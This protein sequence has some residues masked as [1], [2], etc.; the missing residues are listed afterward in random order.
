MLAVDDDLEPPAGRPAPGHDCDLGA[1]EPQLGRGVLRRGRE[2]ASRP[3]HRRLV[4]VFQAPLSV[5]RWDVARTS[6]RPTARPASV[7]VRCPTASSARA[8]QRCSRV[9][10]S[11]TVQAGA[12]RCLCTWTRAPCRH[13]LAFRA[14]RSE[15]RGG[16]AGAHGD[17]GGARVRRSSGPDAGPQADRGPHTTGGTESSSDVCRAARAT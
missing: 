12:A 17:H 11:W 8:G 14:R 10:S 6:K 7:V 4:R 1:I 16:V 15:P 13:I 9:R 5:T 3:G 2:P